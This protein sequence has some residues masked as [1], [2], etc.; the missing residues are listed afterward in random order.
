MTDAP[1]GLLSTVRR[2]IVVVSTMERGVRIAFM[3]GAALVSLAI[4]INIF[5]AHLGPAVSIRIGTI[6][7]GALVVLAAGEFAVFFLL[8]LTLI[9]LRGRWQGSANGALAALLLAFL[10]GNDFQA[11]AFLA[12]VPA[13]LAWGFLLIHGRAPL[14]DR[15]A[16]LAALCVSLAALLVAVVYAA[17]G[18]ELLIVSALALQGVIAMVGLCMAATDIAELAIV[19]VESVTAALARFLRSV[20]AALLFALLAILIDLVLPLS[21][22]GWSARTVAQQLGAGTGVALWLGLIYW[23]AIARR[24]RLGAVHVHIDY[25]ALFLIVGG[26]F[27]ALQAGAMLRLLADPLTYRARDLFTYPEVFTFTTLA[28]AVC[29][30]AFL[31]IGRRSERIL[32]RLAYAVTVGLFIFHYYASRGSNIVTIVV[33][34]GMGSLLLLMFAPLSRKIR[35]NYA[36]FCLIVA[37]LNL[38]FVAYALLAALFFSLGGHAHHG[39]LTTGQA[40]IVLGA[41]AWDMV[42]SGE[43]ITNRHSEAFPRLARVAAFM[44][45]VISVA[46]MVLVSTQAHLTNPVTGE[47]AESVFNSELLVG[48]GL[49]LFGAPL[50]FTMGMLR[51]RNL[52]AA[53]DASAAAAPEPDPQPAPPPAASTAAA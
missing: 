40:L 46:L 36:A 21:L 39:A 43:A 50:I 2:R 31:A 42:A 3:A 17:S 45:Y 48:V 19:A 11:M 22:T 9:L 52:L 12:L 37:D 38:A 23:M 51:L 14:A 7:V 33:A 34:V 24:R 15:E 10:W 28:A 1:S 20:W 29:I 49:I 16:M 35:A 13:A 25:R 30:V 41:L 44:A 4:L 47:T 6:P 8:T 18:H 26:Y 53:A 5:H 32:V 27:L